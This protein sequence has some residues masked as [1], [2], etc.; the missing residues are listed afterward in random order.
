VIDFVVEYLYSLSFP[1]LFG[2][3]E[4]I[5]LDVVDADVEKHLEETVEPDVLK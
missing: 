4:A 1:P 2:F 3:S 5:D